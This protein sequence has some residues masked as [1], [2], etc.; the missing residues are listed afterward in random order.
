M[1]VDLFRDGCGMVASWLRDGCCKPNLKPT[2]TFKETNRILS[3]TKDRRAGK[4]RSGRRQAAP[5]VVWELP[6]RAWRQ[7]LAGRF[8]AQ[9]NVTILMFVCQW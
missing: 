9:L 3:G 5:N 2:E 6:G 1:I 8:L 7:W 4:G